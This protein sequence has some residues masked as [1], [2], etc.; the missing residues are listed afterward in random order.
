MKK[1]I[2]Y[3]LLILFAARAFSQQ[4]DTVKIM[5][6]KDYRARSN[7]QKITGFV[8]LGA[9]VTCL[10]IASGGNAEFDSLPVLV[11]GGALATLTSI[12]LFIAAGRNKRKAR[13]AVAGLK[14]ESAPSIQN[15]F[16]LHSY[17]AISVKINL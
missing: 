1:I 3:S 10:G 17:P 5:T 7:G 16:V 2:V 11:I 9:G 12:P 15:N 13:N 8:L 6:R 4:T 14:L